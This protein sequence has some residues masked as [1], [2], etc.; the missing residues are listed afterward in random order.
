MYNTCKVLLLFVLCRFGEY[1]EYEHLKKILLD[2]ICVEPIEYTEDDDLKTETKLQNIKRITQRTTSQPLTNT[3]RTCTPRFS[4]YL[5]LRRINYRV[6]KTVE[7]VL[8]KSL[9]QV[10]IR[11]TKRLV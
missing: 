4:V 8:T 3:S 11:Q 5:C 2:S 7:F 10:N 1:S 6:L 9:F